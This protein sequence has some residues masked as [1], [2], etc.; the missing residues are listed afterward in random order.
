MGH[1]KS[2]L[3]STP[4]AKQEDFEVVGARRY[5]TGILPPGE[6][7]YARQLDASEKADH[8]FLLQQADI[9]GP[10]FKT[11]AWDELHI[12]IVG[13]AISRRFLA[14]HE[15]ALD[16][17]APELSLLFPKGFLPGMNA[18]DHRDYRRYLVRAIRAESATVERSSLVNFIAERLRHYADTSGDHGDTADAFSAAMSAIA[19]GLLIQVFFGAVPGTTSFVRLMEG[20]SRLGPY[21]LVWNP[22]QRQAEAFRE[23]RDHLRD[24]LSA[25][26]NGSAATMQTATTSLLRELHE[27][28]ALDDT[29]LGNLIYMVEMGRSD[30]Q[31]FFRWIT[32]FAARNPDATRNVALDSAGLHGSGANVPATNTPTT[33]TPTTNTPTTNAEAFILEV[34]RAEQ[35]ERLERR[36]NKDMMFEGFL[37]PAE[38]NVR[39]CL[40]EPHHREDLFAQPHRFDA[41][42][43]AGPTP[44]LDTFAPFGLDH[45]QC[46]FGGLT[47]RIGNAF[48]RTLAEGF[49][50]TL[51]EDGP[52]IRGAYH[53]EPSRYLRVH[54]ETK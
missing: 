35:A 46:P 17:L 5:R 29:M 49:A 27:E 42:R 3:Q 7:N 28:G 32:T 50:I 12:C 16:V 34:L 38:T 6:L 44:P 47:M 21:G 1:T 8:L 54:L 25:A 22:Q 24:D 36:T 23:L 26:A 30:M 45:H 9:H 19:T 18:D 33:N 13:L 39:L 14:D 51:L 37:I 43:F 41:T 4:T 31:N 2:A 40:W 15:L 53:W 11:I 10:I 20:F 48:I 52:S